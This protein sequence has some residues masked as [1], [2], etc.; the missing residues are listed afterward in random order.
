MDIYSMSY[1]NLK[2]LFYS[3]NEKVKD[4]AKIKKNKLTE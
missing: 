4:L 3:I 1:T 2:F